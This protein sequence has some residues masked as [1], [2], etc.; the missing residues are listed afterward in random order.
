M[1]YHQNRHSRRIRRIRQNRRFVGIPISSSIA[2]WRN[3]AK[4]AILAEFAGFTKIAASSVPLSR[5]QS[6][7]GEISPKSPFSPNSPDSPKSPLCRYPYLELNRSLAKFRQNRHSRRIRRIRQNRRFVGTP[8]SS[9]IAL[10]RNFAKI[11][12]LAEF[13]GFAKIAASSVPLSRAQS[14]FGEISPKPP[15]SPNLPDSPKSPLRRYPYLELN[16]SLA[17]Y[18]QNHHSRRICRIRQNRRFVGTPISSSIA[19]W[20]NFAKIAILAEFAGFAKIAASSV[21]L[22]RAQSLLAKF[23][24]NRH[25]RPIRRF[26]QNRR[27][28]GTPISSSIALWRNIAKIAILAE[29]AGFA[30]IAASSVPLSRAQ[31]PF[32]E[33]SP[34]S[35]LSPNSPDSPKSPLRRYPYLELNRCLAKF[36]QNRHSR[37]IR[38]FRQNRRFVG[39]PILSSIA[40]WRNIAKIAILAEFAGFAKIA[41]SSVFLSRAQSLFGEISPKSPF[42]PN[43]PDS[44]K[45]PLRRYPY[46]EL[47]RS[48]AKYRQNHHS[49]RICRIRQN[50]RFVGTPISS[51]IALWQNFAKIAILAECAGFAKI[52]ASSVP[53]SR[54]QSLFGEISPKS[55][56]SPSSPDSPKSPLCRYPYL[57]LNRSLAKYRQNHH[58]RRICRIRQIAAS[59]VPLSRAQS[60]FGK[61]SPKSPLR[62]YP[63]LE[64]NRCLVKFR[65]N[66]HSGRIRRFRQNRCFIG[67]PIL[68]SIALWRNIAKIAILA[69]FAGFAKIAASSVSLSRAESL[70]GEISPKS[71]CSPNLLD[72]PKSPLRRYPYLELNR[73][74]AKYRE[75]HHSR[76]ICRIRQN[77]RFVGTPISSSI[78]LWRNFAKIAILAEFAGFAKIAASS[79]PL[80]RAQSL[81]GEISPKSPF[82]PNSPV[83]PKSPLRRY[84]YLELNRS[85]AKYCQNRHSRRIC[86]IRQNRRFVGTPI[87]SSIAVWRNFAKIA[88]L[89]E[90]AGFAKIAA[91]SVPLSRAQ[92]PFGEISPKSPFSPNSPDSI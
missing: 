76:R 11:A 78:A 24:Q 86:R 44:P 59:S 55:P 74:L 21:P 53:L 50:R 42:S 54:A 36:R 30:K 38:R 79:V 40:V 77:R 87:L 33:I 84:P 37:R 88:I 91:S 5:A 16:R 82:S 13:A 27:F 18:R 75:N 58:S 69:E 51:S 41:A 19:L 3:I 34:K 61:I 26:R 4:I 81:F 60:P 71:P 65:Q 47:N 89:A 39:T 25:S 2:L 35:P 32:G 49:R 67:T 17:K 48:L 28:V 92:S 7:F 90:F 45:S 83:S 10:W 68:S 52:A 12:I 23:G 14:L 20:P 85:L 31:S 57:E 9:S 22:S 43:L 63:Y 46:L 1:K 15:F 62:R 8:I 66:R 6:L 72:S 29:F 56:F 80:S 70:F 64:L 73:S